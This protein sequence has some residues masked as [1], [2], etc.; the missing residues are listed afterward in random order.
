MQGSS[1]AEENLICGGNSDEAIFIPFLFVHK[2]LFYVYFSN[3][4]STS[5]KIYLQKIL[6]IGRY[7]LRVE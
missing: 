4:T 7:L 3:T 2:S 1:H 6:F 5:I